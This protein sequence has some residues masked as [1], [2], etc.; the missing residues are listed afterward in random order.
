MS[1]LRIGPLVV[2]S[3]SVVRSRSLSWSSSGGPARRRSSRASAEI[4]PSKKHEFWPS[5]LF[6]TNPLSEKPPGDRSQV[7]PDGQ[8]SCFT[9]GKP[10]MLHWPTVANTG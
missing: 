7:S 3:S 6:P 1:K 8:S 10:L 4:A 2:I 5:R 9:Q